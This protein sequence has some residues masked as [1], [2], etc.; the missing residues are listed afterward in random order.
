MPMSKD[1][2]KSSRSVNVSCDFQAILAMSRLHASGPSCMVGACQAGG[3]APVQDC[4]LE[5]SVRDCMLEL[6]SGLSQLFGLEGPFSSR[7]EG[8]PS[9]FET[10]LERVGLPVVTVKAVGP[11]LDSG[12]HDPT[13]PEEVS[14]PSELAISIPYTS[15]TVVTYSPFTSHEWECTLGFEVM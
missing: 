4:M 7:G 9:D 10:Y 15:S 5:L 3:V 6:G 14:S 11:Q 2:S 13:L 1:S 12:T 8:R